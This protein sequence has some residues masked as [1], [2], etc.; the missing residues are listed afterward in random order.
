MHTVAEQ[1]THLIAAAAATA[2]HDDTPIPLE[3]C[4]PTNN[5]DHG[6]YQSNFAFRL[7]KFLRTNP[8]EVAAQIVSALPAH[9][10]V[11]DASVAGPGFVNFRLADGWLSENVQARVADPRLGAPAPGEGRTV[12]IDYSSPNIAKRM[13]VG[14]LRSTIIGNALHRIL[15]FLQYTVVA[16][17]HVGDWGTQFG[18]LIVG[19]HGWRDSAAYD[20]DPI[21]EL[22]RIYQA[23]GEKAE[24]DSTLI[25]QAR[26]ETAKLQRGDAEN[27]ALWTQFVRAS[28]VEFESIYARL[29][30][31]FDVVHGESFY[32]DG[33]QA[34]IDEL[35]ASGLATHNE[36]A[37]IVEFSPS[38]GKGLKTPLLIRKSDGA[39][40]YGTTDLATVRHRMETWSPSDI[41]YVTDLRQK[42]HFRQVFATCRKMGVS[43]VD[44]HHVPFG[45]LRFP[46]GAVAATRSG[47]TVNLV[48]VL[49][50]AVAK[51]RAIVDEGSSH[52]PEEERARIAE[53]VGVGAVKYFDLSQNPQSDITFDWDRSLA[54]DGNS[55]P[56]MMYAYARCASILRK[57]EERGAT[58]TTLALSHPLERAV[59][60]DIVRMGE[61]IE[62]AARTWRPN[63]LAE[64]LY[65]L[66]QS[67]SRFFAEC[68]VLGEDPD[69]TGSRLVLTQVTARALELGLDLLGVTVQPRM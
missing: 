57:A 41:V 13:H 29:G 20:R 60:M 55:A 52:L 10:M 59:A 67:F 58:P 38:D 65:G 17:N 36:G 63:L 5:P 61:V 56:Y 66:S 8:R 24:A 2:G 15:S 27:L 39:A 49:D 69:V 33:L 45:I 26:A 25:D 34:L 4:V 35:L 18:K 14:H 68:R 37:V 50:T 19:W 51:A 48:D 9:P 28:M 44:F 32:R 12:V 7:G 21:A 6:D 46:D 31:S 43:D 23:F 64:H 30:V 53:A 1:L 22:Q 40:L 47:G 3:P 11:A 42:L 62:Q 16:D 54:L